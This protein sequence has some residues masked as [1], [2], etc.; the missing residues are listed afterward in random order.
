MVRISYAIDRLSAMVGKASGWS[1]VVLTLFISA[2]V[3]SRYVLLRPHAWATDI[4]T[5][6][7]GT[8]IMLGGAFTLS[9]NGHVRADLIYAALS[10]RSQAALD[11]ALY[12]IF[13]FPGVLALVYAGFHFAE[14]AWAINERSSTMA[15]GPPLFPFKAMIPTAGVLLLLQGFAEVMRCIIC[16]VR[17]EW[18]NRVVDVQEVDLEKLKEIVREKP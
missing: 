4:Q 2:E 7:Y 12:L 14:Q 6:L 11:L 3:F 9:Q 13:F 18:P 8:L 5:M 15:G 10:S 17:G 16:L 1:I